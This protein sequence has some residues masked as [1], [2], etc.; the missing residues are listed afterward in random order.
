MDLKKVLVVDDDVDVI[1]VISTILKK[2]GFEPITAND[3]VE[4]LRKAIEEKPVLAILDVMMSTHYEGFE[5][6]KEIAENPQTKHIPRLMQ[7]SIEIFFSPIPEIMDMAREY[8]KDPKHR[9]LEVLLIED[10][11]TGK[12]GIDYRDEKGETV[13]VPVDGFIK[14]PLDLN[15]L[16][17]YLKR[18]GLI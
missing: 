12:A 5:L 17:P 13:W 7:T 11:K 4:G 2:E 8:R 10:K 15:N 3:K 18:L 9:E 14:K 16:T 6:A 1:L